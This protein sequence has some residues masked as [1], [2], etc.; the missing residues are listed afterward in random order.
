METYTPSSQARKKA[1]R[2]VVVGTVMDQTP[3]E[4]VAEMSWRCIETDFNGSVSTEQ[5]EAIIGF[6][7]AFMRSVVQGVDDYMNH[8]WT[9][10]PYDD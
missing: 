3:A 2:A 1:I 5:N 6:N 9:P 8:R 7:V 10:T 4:I